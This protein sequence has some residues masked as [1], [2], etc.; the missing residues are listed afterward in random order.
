MAGWKLMVFGGTRKKTNRRA[1]I[2]NGDGRVKRVDI[3]GY[4]KDI[5][6]RYSS[7]SRRDNERF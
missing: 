4:Q 2:F 1:G 3:T 6:I 5:I 7:S